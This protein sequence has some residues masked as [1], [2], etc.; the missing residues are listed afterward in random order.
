[1]ESGEDLILTQDFVGSVCRVARRGTPKDEI[2][3]VPGNENDF[4]RIPASMIGDI[5]LIS[6]LKLGREIFF[7]SWLIDQLIDVI[8]T[9][10]HHLNEDVSRV[11][12]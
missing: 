5:E 8:G 1:L 9:I 6:W 2:E 4:I 3:V 12:N 11:N 10:R 7:E